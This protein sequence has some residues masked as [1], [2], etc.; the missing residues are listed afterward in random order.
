[1]QNAH[2]LQALV[3]LLMV[4]F[5]SDPVYRGPGGASHMNLRPRIFQRQI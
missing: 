1:V 2:D 5:R 4:L 3:Q